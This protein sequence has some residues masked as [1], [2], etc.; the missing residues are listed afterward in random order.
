[1]DYFPLKAICRDY[2]L[3]GL[4]CILIT[5]ACIYSAIDKG[6]DSWPYNSV[7]YLPSVWGYV[8]TAVCVALLIAFT[9]HRSR[10]EARSPRHFIQLGIFILVALVF[11]LCI[12]SC[13][14][15]LPN[16]EGDGTVE[17]DDPHIRL[18]LVL[19]TELIEDF[20][21]PRDNATA[22]LWRVCGMMYIVGALGLVRTSLHS[23]WDRVAGLAY[24]AFYPAVLNFCGHND[25]YAVEY[26]C[27]SA[28]IGLLFLAERKS[29]LPYLTAAGGAFVLSILAK[30]LSLI[31]IIFPACWF[32]LR[33]S[34][35]GLSR[36][37][38]KAWIGLLAA[39]VYIT[40]LYLFIMRGVPLSSFGHESNFWFTM[41]REDIGLLATLY[42]P[43]HPLMPVLIPYGLSF[44]GL[45]L[46]SPAR[47][48]FRQNLTVSSAVCGSLAVT[49]TIYMV[50]L[51]NPIAVYGI[52]DSLTLS[53]TIGAMLVIPIFIL[54]SRGQRNH[55]PTLATLCVFITVPRLV[56]Q[57]LPIE[58]MRTEKCLPGEHSRY[59]LQ[60][61]PCGHVASRLLRF[62]A[63][64]TTAYD[65]YVRGVYSSDDHRKF[66]PVNLYSLIREQYLN[67]DLPAGRSNLRAC[68]R[69]WPEILGFLMV[70]QPFAN[71]EVFRSFISDC[72]VMGREVLQSTGDSSHAIIVATCGKLPTNSPPICSQLETAAVLV[73]LDYLKH[74]GTKPPQKEFI[75]LGEETLRKLGFRTVR[76]QKVNQ[77]LP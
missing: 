32:L 64:R 75:S 10:L 42:C 71:Q 16:L 22:L 1:M 34:S 48:C 69:R 44:L 40:A 21:L 62:P 33:R 70:T 52:F 77:A 2:Y 65:F 51:F 8:F 24:F 18:R 35:S 54:A 55:L 25:S 15:F 60:E 57:H 7:V 4:V 27:I 59:F 72:T 43:L 38:I 9:R 23:F 12:Y 14:P 74:P 41:T 68:L 58:L 67:G 76:V 29:S 73:Y 49:V 5:A 47:H 53:G 30:R 61:S 17:D 26:I 66:A 20:S 39:V 46:S 13:R 37:A 45:L 63:L 11:L 56:V 28:T 50:Q 6:Y 19:L 3:P 31:I 36:P